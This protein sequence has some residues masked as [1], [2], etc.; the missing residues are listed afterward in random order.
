MSAA[1]TTQTDPI[2]SDEELMS[3]LAAGRQDA[4]GPLHGRYASLVYNVAAQTIGGATAEEIVQ[5]VFVAVWRKAGTFDPSRG[6]FRSWV[7]RIAHLRVLNELRRRGRRIKVERDPEGLRIGSV[8][9]PGPGPPDEAW[10]THRRAIVRQAVAALPPPQRQALSLAFLEDLTH[11]QI[12]DFLG[13]PLGTTK[14]RIRAGLHALRAHLSPLFATGLLVLGLV[15][16]FHLRERSRLYY[17]ALRLVTSSD[18]V[19]RRMAATSG[20]PV[21]TE[22]HGNYRGRPGT[23]LA[24][25]TFSHFAPAPAGRAYEAWGEFD[26]RW[27][28]LGTVH[29]KDDGSDLLIAEGP[30][31]KLPPAALKVTLET[32]GTPRAPNGPT[33]IAWPNP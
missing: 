4:L 3:Q 15:S 12:A 24:V 7:L 21:Q 19:P 33:V 18:I 31:L 17:E 26:S 10:R 1:D 22:T 11:E 2:Q 8:P 20:P 27:V 14:S 28:H 9:E 29:P 16:F 6:T 30:H 25:L 32:V 5:D 13:L 23:P